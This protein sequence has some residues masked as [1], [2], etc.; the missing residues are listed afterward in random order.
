MHGGQLDLARLRG[1]DNLLDGENIRVKCQD[2]FL[3]IGKIDLKRNQIN[4]GCII[5]E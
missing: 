1:V 3:G 2:E 5:K 4:I